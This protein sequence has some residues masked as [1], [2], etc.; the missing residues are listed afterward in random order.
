[1][2]RFEVKIDTSELRDLEKRLAN[3][4]NEVKV[5]AFHAAR[6]HV[7]NK[8]RT[9][10]GR[11]LAK[12]TRLK[13][14]TVRPLLQS[15]ASGANALEVKVKSRWISLTKLD[16]TYQSDEGVETKL[17]GSYKSAFIATMRSTGH[18]GAFRRLEGD[19]RLPIGEVFGPNP[20]HA[21]GNDRHGEFAKLAEEMAAE[22]IL[23]R[24]LHEI[25]FRLGRLTGGR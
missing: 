13:Y 18:K 24:Y 17:H 22:L 2:S 12:Y 15:S 9:Q 19:Q 20:A 21:V 7:A 25:E 8:L 3:V 16:G 4:P 5:K 6:K 14:G 10:V 23:P 11:K 1:M